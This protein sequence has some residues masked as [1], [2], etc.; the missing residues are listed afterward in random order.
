MPFILGVRLTSAVSRLSGQFYKLTEL[1]LEDF[2]QFDD[3]LL[4]SSGN[5]G[6]TG[7][8]TIHHIRTMIEDQ[9]T[10]KNLTNKE[11]NQLYSFNNKIS[12]NPSIETIQN[13]CKE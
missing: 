5:T 6:Y 7:L 11:I 12:L 3:M 13:I 4:G 10:D 1:S 9:Q 2:H 8:Y